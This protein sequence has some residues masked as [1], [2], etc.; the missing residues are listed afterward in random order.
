MSTAVEVIK[1]L[2][3][4]TQYNLIS[5]NRHR[6]AL[7]Q[8][9]LIH[10]GDDGFITVAV[11][12]KYKKWT[13]HHYKKHELENNI[14]KLLGLN[15]DTYMSINS[16]YVPKRS[17]ECVRHINSLYVDIDNHSSKKVNVNSI[18][19]FLEEDFFYKVIPIPSLIIETGRGLAL[20]W[21]LEHLPKQGLPLWTLVQ[22]QLYKKVKDIESYIQNIEVDPTA[23]DVSR[24]FRIS[25]SRNTKSKTLAKIYSYDEV[26]YRLDEIIEGYFPELEIVKKEKKKKIKLTDNQK[27]IVYFH[28]IYSLH[29]SRLLDLVKLQQLRKGKCTGYREVMCFLYRYYNCL[30]VRDYDIALKNTLEFNSKFTEPLQYIEVVK[31]TKKAEEAYEEW[32]KNEPVI[33]NGR[34]YKR[35]GYNYTSNKL[36]ELLN[37]TK[38]E[39]KHLITIIGKDEKY[40]RNNIRRTPR[41]KEGLTPRQQEKA[42]KE[43]LIKELVNKG[44]NKS[45]VADE[46]GV[47]RSTITRYYGYLF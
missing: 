34:V 31:A 26:K 28:T 1:N 4:I 32:L 47:N 45:Q 25:G 6:Q 5:K 2:D 13:Q 15:I 23:L 7:K 12:D 3:T 17:T 9:N 39:Q 29:Y 22:E 16:F 42:K 21:V 35:G 10:D 41:N 36:I 37:V 24:V 11:K 46:L 27:K 19:Y 20:Y 40:R 8:L 44:L 18:L 38:E 43:K 14:F 30:Y 33:K